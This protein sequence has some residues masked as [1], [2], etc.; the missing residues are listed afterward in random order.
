[1]GSV[2]QF[3]DLKL[4]ETEKIDT[5]VEEILVET[6][7][8]SERSR[9]EIRAWFVKRFAETDSISVNLHVPAGID[10][11]DPLI[12]QFLDETKTTLINAVHETSNL[13][14]RQA[15]TWAVELYLR[16]EGQ[17]IP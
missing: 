2:I 12:K 17:E 7:T 13:H 11:N 3:P 10:I 15:L 16:I 4:R 5:C 1:M 14:L 8:L 9:A 6:T